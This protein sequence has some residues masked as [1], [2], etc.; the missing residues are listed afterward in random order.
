MKK[1]LLLLL[2]LS[3]LLTCCACAKP[4]EPDTEPAAP[5]IT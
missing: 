2:A 3:L 4:T 5:E 1:A